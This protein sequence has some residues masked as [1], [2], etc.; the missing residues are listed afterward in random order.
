MGW[1][2]WV[3][4]IRIDDTPRRFRMKWGVTLLSAGKAPIF[5]LRAFVPG[6]TYTGGVL[7][8]ITKA[9]MK[10]TMKT[11]K[12]IFAR[13]TAVPAMPPKPSAAAMSAMTRK[14]MA[15]LIIMLLEFGVGLLIPPFHRDHYGVFTYQFLTIGEQPKNFGKP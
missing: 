7:R 5:E 8:P 13:P 12:R 1:L 11:K 15:Q 6:N 10:S 2:C 14:V 9:M 4:R 3:F